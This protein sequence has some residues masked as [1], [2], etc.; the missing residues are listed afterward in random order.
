MDL[1]KY[2]LGAKFCRNLFKK[3]GVCI[4]IHES[5]QFT[6]INLGKFCKEKDLEVCAAKLHL[7]QNELCIVVIYRSPLGNLQHFLHK[8]ED[9]LNMLYSNTTE[10]MICGDLN[11]NHLND[12]T[13]KHY[14]DLI[15]ASYGLSSIV[16]FL[17]GIQK[18]F[19]F[20]NR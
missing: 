6:N 4:F 16:N 17:T 1:T 9:I 7:S 18:K 3:G 19:L 5:I 8:I 12:S 13:S 14:L 11:I 2:N 15:L 10:T 20:H